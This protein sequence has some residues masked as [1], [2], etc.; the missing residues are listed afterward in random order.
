M[1]AP[2]LLRIEKGEVYPMAKRTYWN[3]IP[4]L[5]LLLT[6]A[7]L[8]SSSTKVLAQTAPPTVPSSAP[9]NQSEEDQKIEALQKQLQQ[10]QA[11]LDQMKKEKA[12]SPP[13]STT[14]ASAPA[15]T[16]GT[17]P[18]VTAAASPEPAAAAPSALESVFDGTSISGS[19][20]GYYGYDFNEPANRTATLRSFD[21]MQNQFALN[22]AE[23]V[24]KKAPDSTNRLGYNLTFGYG[25]AMNV[26]NGSEPV[27]GAGFDRNV[28]QAYLSYLVPVGKGLQVDFGKFVTPAG[29]EVI[30][31]FS[32]WN[33]SR[34]VLFSY[35]IPFFHFGLRAAY[36]F[37]PRYSLTAFVLNG[38]NDVVAP[39]TGKTYGASFAWNATKK[40]T[41]TQNYLAGPQM[42]NINQHWRQ[43]SDT[44]VQYNVTS[45]LSLLE[46]YDWGGGDMIPNYIGP[47]H[48]N[49]IASYVRY[50]FNDK[51]ALA[52]RY[53]YYDDR[54]GFTTGMPQDI[55]EYTATLERIFAQHLTTRLEFRRDMSNAPFFPQGTSFAKN[56]NTLEA[57]LMYV[58]NIHEGH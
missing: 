17:A 47:V 29:A 25:N 34:G 18:A 49:G 10:L 39:N 27:A 58:F 45:K 6:G 1:I 16:A 30:E 52:V 26:V 50:A 43:L 38:W 2:I 8:L 41:V 28:E 20:D 12:G 37:S 4:S 11:E 40:L 22:L 46:N 53:E 35:A 33:Y 55:N 9:T 51:E 57:G 5:L 3:A 7:C 31:S 19:V 24:I 56:Q 15:A 42:L 48:W 14:G 13:A 21:N 44:V 32:D 23:L 54:S 36:T